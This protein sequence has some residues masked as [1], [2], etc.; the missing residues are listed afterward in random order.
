MEILRRIPSSQRS[1]NI[2]MNICVDHFLKSFNIHKKLNIHA[3]TK[4]TIQITIMLNLFISYKMLINSEINVCNLL[5][6][7]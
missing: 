3:V 6:E 4:E 5:Y 2:Y 1:L 7:D